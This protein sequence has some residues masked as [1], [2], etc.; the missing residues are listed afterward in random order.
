MKG[1][2]FCTLK[3]EVPRKKEAIL[4]FCAS[5]KIVKKKEKL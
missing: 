3:K 4:F 5:K 1:N 2:R